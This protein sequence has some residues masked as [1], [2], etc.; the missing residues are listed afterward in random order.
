MAGG[1]VICRKDHDITNGE[2]VGGIMKDIGIGGLT[3]EG[4]MTSKARRNVRKGMGK[5]PMTEEIP[6]GDDREQMSRMSRR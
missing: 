1:P 3:K 6:T 4:E 2:V 5:N